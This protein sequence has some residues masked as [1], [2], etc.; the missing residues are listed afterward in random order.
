VPVKPVFKD[1]TFKGFSTTSGK[2]RVLFDIE[3]IKEDLLNN[4]YTRKG[5]RPMQPD[6]GSIIWDILFEPYDD[7]INSI[8]QEDLTR[9]VNNDPRL[10]LITMTIDSFE[11]GLI[12][13][14]TVAYRPFNMTETLE[15]TF[16]NR[17]LENN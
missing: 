12:V 17:M 15:V 11:Y 3:L 8:V 4:I 13:N 16:D 2:P 14:M 6:Y 7:S 1:R 10:E 9:I 5:E